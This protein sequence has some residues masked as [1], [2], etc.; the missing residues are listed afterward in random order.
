MNLSQKVIGR[1]SE[2]PPVFLIDG[3][4]NTVTRIDSPTDSKPLQ[5]NTLEA[6]ASKATPTVSIASAPKPTGRNVKV[7]FELET[8]DTTETYYDDVIA[9][10]G[11]LILC[12]DHACNPSAVFRPGKR[13]ESHLALQVSSPDGKHSQGYLC[14]VPGIHFRH[15]TVEYILLVIADTMSM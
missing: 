1:S 11:T 9:T 6:E 14:Y 7:V 13:L 3:R 12:I 2:K 4:N 15:R 10:E 5:E 8:G